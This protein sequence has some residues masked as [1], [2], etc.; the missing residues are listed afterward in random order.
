MDAYIIKGYRTAVTRAKKGKFKNTR[1]DDLAV[2][3]IK[4][5]V[6]SIEGFTAP[7][8]KKIALFISAWLNMCNKVAVKPVT[9]LMLKPTII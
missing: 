3:T 9:V 5:L 6:N 7:R 2:D 4:Y 1:P 8:A